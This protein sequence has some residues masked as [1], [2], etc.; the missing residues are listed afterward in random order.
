MTEYCFAYKWLQIRMNYNVAII[1]HYKS[2]TIDSQLKQNFTIKLYIVNVA[3][4]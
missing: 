4:Q 2:V 3:G 1:V